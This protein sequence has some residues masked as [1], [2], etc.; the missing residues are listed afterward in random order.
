M[1]LAW[2]QQQLQH[3]CR[4]DVDAH[5]TS[6]DVRLKQHDT[7]VHN[8]PAAIEEQRRG[9]A[10]TSYQLG[11]V[12]SQ[13]NSIQKQTDLFLFLCNQ[14]LSLSR[15]RPESPA[16][17]VAATQK[18]AQ[19]DSFTCTSIWLLAQQHAADRPAEEAARKLACP[20][21]PTDDWQCKLLSLNTEGAGELPKPQSHL[22]P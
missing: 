2:A 21:C 11:A 18:T 12:A 9:T 6:A 7:E 1:L 22:T 19:R 13:G 14:A 15:C 16:I 8:S 5:T 3:R 17:P 4:A 10:H 20:Q